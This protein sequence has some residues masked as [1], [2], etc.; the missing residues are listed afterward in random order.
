[1]TR[2]IDA[3]KFRDWIL[4]QKRLSKHYTV[5]M[6][7][8]TPPADVDEVR[9]GEW[10]FEGE[11]KTKSGYRFTYHCSRCF[12][13]VKRDSDEPPINEIYPYCHCGAKMDGRVPTGEVGRMAKYY[14]SGEEQYIGI[15]ETVPV[16]LIKRTENDENG[17]L[18]DLIKCAYIRIKIEALDDGRILRAPREEIELALRLDAPDAEIVAAADNLCCRIRP[19]ILRQLEILTGRHLIWEVG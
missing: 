3:Q 17:L 13:L 10:I 16:N 2:Y 14:Q 1:M 7:D 4:K 12:R 5:Q 19:E 18:D 8:E 11:R 15:G 9:H 6:L